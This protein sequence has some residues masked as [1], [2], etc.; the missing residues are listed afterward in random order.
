MFENDGQDTQ[1]RDLAEKIVLTEDT[2][3][4][5]KRGLLV[6]KERLILLFQQSGQLSTKLDSGLIP[7][8]ETQQRISKRGEV[9]TEDLFNWLADNDMADIIKPTVHQKTLQSTLE[10]YIAKGNELPA[11]MFN[12]FDQVVLR[13]SEKAKFLR[14]YNHEGA[15]SPSE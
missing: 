11:D 10:G 7:R 2:I 1:I 12:Q 13:F 15:Q 3:D 9:E 14:E 6:D 8:I 4:Q 5:L